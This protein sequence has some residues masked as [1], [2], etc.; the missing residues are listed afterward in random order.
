MDAENFTFQSKFDLD[1]PVTITAIDVKGFVDAIQFDRNETTYA[2][3]YWYD[4]H[5][6][7]VWCS[8]RELKKLS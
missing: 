7:R 3:V 1:E 2:V 8:S 6:Q 5:R 4:G